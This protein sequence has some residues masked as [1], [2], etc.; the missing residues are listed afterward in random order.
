MRIKGVNIKSMPVLGATVFAIA[1]CAT[2]QVEVQPAQPPGVVA[3]AVTEAVPA[4]GE[5]FVD[6]ELAVSKGSVQA[7]FGRA[8]RNEKVEIGSAKLTFK[9]PSTLTVTKLASRDKDAPG[10][11]RITP[12]HPWIV[13][14]PFAGP[15]R[16][17]FNI[18][19]WDDDPV[20]TAAVVKL[21]GAVIFSG[22]GSEDDLNGWA[23]KNYGAGVNK[24]GS[25]E[26]AFL[27]P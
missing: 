6:I 2:A 7:Y 3:P 23:V 27:V 11:Q 24:T 19:E 15:G 22:R 20:V 5:H 8:S 12:D 17:V 21:D 9:A 14:V 25:R 26:I 18:V 4:P 1:G 16:Y 13:R 10:S